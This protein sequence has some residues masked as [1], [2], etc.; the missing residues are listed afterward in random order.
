MTIGIDT[1]RDGAQCTPLPRLL[2]MPFIGTVTEYAINS[3]RWEQHD[4]P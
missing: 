3:R 2:M 4:E 1:F